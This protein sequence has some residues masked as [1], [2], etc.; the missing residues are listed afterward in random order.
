MPEHV[1]GLTAYHE[2]MTVLVQALKNDVP[3]VLGITLGFNDKDG[4]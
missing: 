4:D 3:P 2:A 1:A